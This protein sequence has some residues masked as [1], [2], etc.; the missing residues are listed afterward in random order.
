MRKPRGSAFGDSRAES[1]LDA[2]GQPVVEFVL[3]P[4]KHPAYQANQKDER[5]AD[6]DVG[7]FDVLFFDPLLVELCGIINTTVVTR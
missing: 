4:N 5:T 6:I 1:R 3:S 2:F 7:A